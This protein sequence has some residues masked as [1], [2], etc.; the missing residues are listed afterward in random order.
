VLELIIKSQ[1]PK[2]DNCMVYEDHVIMK[3]PYLEPYEHTSIQSENV[4]MHND[5]ESIPTPLYS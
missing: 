5:K 1:D 2:E 3:L 4:R